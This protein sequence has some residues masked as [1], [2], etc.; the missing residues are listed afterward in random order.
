MITQTRPRERAVPV[1]QGKEREGR[2]RG[3]GV[4]AIIT[5]LVVAGAFVGPS[6]LANGAT[7]SGSVGA[8]LEV[9]WDYLLMAPVANVLDTLSLLTM[10]QHYAVL[11][12]LILLYA[13]WRVVRSRRRLGVVRRIGV[14]LGVALLSLL[15]LLAFYAYGALAPRPMAALVAEDEDVVVVDVHSHT[16]HSHDGRDG[17]SAEDNRAWH[18]GAG[19]DAVYVSD[20]RTYE[21]YQDG[22]PG[23]PSRAGAGTVLLPALE[24]KF[25]GKYASVLGEAWR[26]RAA[27]DGNTLIPDSLYR[28]YRSTGIRPTLV[29]TI[30][31]SV[32]NVPPS[33]RDSIGYVA[34]ELSDAAPRGLRQSRRDRA[35]LLRMADSLDLALVAATNNHGWGRTSAAW[36]LM[37]I[38]GWQGMSPAQLSTAIEAKL[39]A[40]RREASRVVERRVP[41]GESPVELAA[42][43]PAITWS[44][45]AGISAAERVSWLVWTWLLA[46]ALALRRR[47][48]E[49]AGA[50]T[51]RPMA[52]AP[53]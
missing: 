23:N 42:T 28:V 50:A 15:G 46:F 24:I 51:A 17:F 32:D 1:S 31:G 49:P 37:R 3:Y 41:F 35:Q 19:F 25:A 4:P 11:A 43:V 44:M 21:G 34:L 48:R 27:M 18:A 12:T 2:V 26:Y 22:V 33:T 5:I 53:R 20:H 39:H 47:R 52:G 30:P 16:Y 36:T 45:F 14:E 29:L 10:P 7:G 38:P 8:R 13:G 40:E 9:G 6:A